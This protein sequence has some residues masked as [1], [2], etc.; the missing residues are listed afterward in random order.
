MFCCLYGG[1]GN[2]GT[3][4]GPR[5]DGVHGYNRQGEPQMQVAILDCIRPEFSPGGRG[6]SD[7]DLGSGGP[8]YLRAVFHQH[9]GQCRGVV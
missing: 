1:T 6:A 2:E 5:P 9:G 8:Q 3:A 7:Q 4:Q